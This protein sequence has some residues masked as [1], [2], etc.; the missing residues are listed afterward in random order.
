M[1]KPP[2]VHDLMLEC[3]DDLP[4]RFTSADV[5]RWFATHHP[6][7]PPS[8]VRTRLARVTEGPDESQTSGTAPVL[9]RV[10]RGVY[11]LMSASDRARGSTQGSAVLFAVTT[12]RH[13]D[14]A[15][16]RKR[17]RLFADSKN[18]AHRN[19]ERWFGLSSH[20]GL[21]HDVD[22]SPADILMSDVPS[23]HG[24]TW[25]SWISIRLDAAM[26]SVR[27]KRIR[28]DAPGQYTALLRPA[29]ESRGADV[30]APPGRG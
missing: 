6:D 14:E 16:R 20:Y 29:L 7:V 10:E 1:T 30:E 2:S 19:G 18:E 5:L 4:E 24:D 8:T 15:Q 22:A 3:A 12:T 11:E 25:A 27:G 28:I 13:P 23:D 26:G 9:R 21:I 17:A